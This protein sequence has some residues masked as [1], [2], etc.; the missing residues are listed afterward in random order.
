MN[1]SITYSQVILIFNFLNI[2]NDLDNAL[3][4]TT[5]EFEPRTSNKKLNIK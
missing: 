1:L 5:L 4:S 2:L 3:V